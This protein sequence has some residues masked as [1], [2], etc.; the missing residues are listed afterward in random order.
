ME[1]SIFAGIVKFGES[2]REPDTHAIYFQKIVNKFPSAFTGKQTFLSPSFSL[3]GNVESSV[4]GD[5]QYHLFFLGEIFNQDEVAAYI[6]SPIS[7]FQNNA[8]LLLDLILQK[9]IGQVNKINGQFTIIFLD[10]QKQKIYILNDHLGIQQLFYYHNK[11]ILLF[12]SE[13]KFLFPYPGCPKEIDWET[14][15]RRPD[16]YIVLS[17]FKSYNTWFKEISLLPEASI[18]EIDLLTGKTKTKKYWDEYNYSSYYPEDDNR[19]AL[20]VMEEYLALLADAVKI[21]I[22][23]ESTGYSCLSGGLDSS[24]ICALAAKQKPMETFSIITQHTCLE[25]TTSVCNKLASDLNFKNTQFLVPFHEL[26]FNAE[27]WKQRVWRAESPVNHTDSFTKTMLHA[28]IQKNNPGI[29]YLLTG[30]GSDQLN[31]GLVRWIAM[32]SETKESSW[33]N[34]INEIVDTENKKLINRVDD[35]LWIMRKFIHRDY[36]AALS[37]NPIEKNSWM[38]C[39]KCALHSEAYSLLWDENHAASSHNHSMRY[40][41]LDYR[42]VEF[43]S[44]IPPRLHQELFFDK[45][46]L[47]EPAKKYLPDYVISKIKAPASVNEYDFRFPLFKFLTSANGGELVKE[48]LGD[49]NEPHPVINKKAL[50]NSIERLKKQPEILEWTYVMQI[51][52]LGL[53]EKLSEKNE[54]DLDYESSLE[55]PVKINFDNPSATKIFLE[56]KLAIK[57]AGEQLT[58]TLHFGEGCAFMYD[59]LN[60]K[61]FLAKNNSLAYEIEAEFIDWKNFLGKINNKL[62]TQQILDELN[63]KFETIEEFFQ[64]SMNEQIL[65]TSENHNPD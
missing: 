54:H 47:R 25:D 19:K 26:S 49:I 15:L 16:P 40:P 2:G 35:G 10:K 12:A 28:A 65:T 42:F 9:G 50:L 36:L 41:F 58:K 56:K 45:L 1:Y 3:T 20:Q 61:Y 24:I 53:L 38:M 7:K 5:K 37:G 17:S 64:L 43:I 6:H 62:S 23:G 31:G 63:I 22:A 14:S 34:F 4:S 39:V 48:A 13:I 8:G 32:D 52:N 55:E 27:L 21:R 51:I 60:D 59:K 57:N 33:V 29:R 30:T 18:F 44:T 46:I 11:N